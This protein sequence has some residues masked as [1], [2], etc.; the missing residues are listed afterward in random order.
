MSCLLI[1]FT[2]VQKYTP[3]NNN[4][5]HHKKKTICKS[6]VGKGK[7][8]GETEFPYKK[9]PPK[10]KDNTIKNRISKIYSYTLCKEKRKRYKRNC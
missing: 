2:T 3:T 4:N 5:H 7:Q 10:L 9:C 6:T 8:Q 1:L